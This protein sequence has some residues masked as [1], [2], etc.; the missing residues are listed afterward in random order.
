[1]AA[2][3]PEAPTGRIPP[4]AK[5]V[6]PVFVSLLILYYYFHDENWQELWK[7]CRNANL[8][9]AMAAVAIPQLIFW[10]FEALIY[11]RHIT[12]F[13][14]PVPFWKLFWVRGAIYILQLINTSIGGGGIFL[15]LQ[16]KTL[17]T[18]R[19]LLGIMLFR[20]GLTLWG[21]GVLMIPATLAVH[22]YGL[23]DKIVLKLY[24]WWPLLIFGV[25]WMT[26]A[27]FVWHH[28]KNF[29]LSK[30]VVRNRESEFWTA[31]RTATRS[32]WLLTWAITLPPFILMLVGFY[33]ATLA[34]GVKVPF[35]EF[36]VVSPLAV[37]IMDLPVAFGG[38]GT[39]TLAWMTFF[40]EYGVEIE[41]D[42]KALTLFIPLARGITR[43]LIGMA[44]L[45]PALRDIYTLSLVSR[46]E[47]PEAPQAP[48]LE[49]EEA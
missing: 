7:A 16:R 28:K 36:M 26:E 4:W 15:Y 37:L 12:W 29:G 18:W 23:A 14:G 17:M 46:K 24:V 33:F 3:I 25:F 40:G 11:D 44:S 42:I 31:F 43:A 48:A 19:K 35:I 13:H 20:A 27:W 8:W 34:F 30:I 45:R 32:Q 9:V 5:K 41:D 22:Y 21:I 10:L 38:F 6:V 39:A 47:E 1:M 2:S 49:E